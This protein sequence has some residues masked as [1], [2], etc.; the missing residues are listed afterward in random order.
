METLAAVPI[1]SGWQFLFRRFIR[2]K[3]FGFFLSIYSS[4]IKKYE[5]NFHT[6]SVLSYSV[7]L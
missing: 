2:E 4:K 7:I 1:V 5:K 6:Y 3:L